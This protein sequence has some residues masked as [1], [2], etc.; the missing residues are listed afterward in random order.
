[1][2]ADLR[3]INVSIGKCKRAKQRAVYDH[4]GGFIDHYEKLWDYRD[5]LLTINLGSS[6][7]LEV[8]TL[9]GGKTVFRMI[10]TCKGELLTTMGRDANNQIFHMDWAVGL[11]EAVRDLLPHVVSGFQEFEVRKA[12]DRFGVNLQQRTCTCKW[13]NLSSIPCMHV[14]VA[15]CF[16]NQDV[17]AGVS[18]WF[19]KQM[20]LNNY[21]Y[22]I[23]PVGGS[24]MWVKSE[25]IP[26]L[27]PKKRKMPG[28]PKKG[29]NLSLKEKMKFL[30]LVGT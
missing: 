8:E 22:F 27:S 5:Q 9:D 21:S 7:D 23:K 12:N 25:N 16:L 24:S 26:T 6:V 30:G 2:K 4:E 18:N 20:W 13:W 28:R 15:Y 3:E 10:S 17:V 19:I 14:V 29:S 11:E 1:M